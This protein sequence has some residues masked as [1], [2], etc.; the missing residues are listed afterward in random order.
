MPF[1]L[2]PPVSGFRAPPRSRRIHAPHKLLRLAPCHYSSR[3]PF[4]TPHLL[5]S[6]NLFL[7]I[8]LNAYPKQYGWMTGFEP[9]TTRSTIWDST[10]EL[11]PP[12]A[13][14][15]AELKTI[16]N[17]YSANYSSRSENPF[18]GLVAWYNQKCMHYAE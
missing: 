4:Q 11:H 15:M 1:S 8:E 5:L 9:A 17:Y 7:K 14:N 6:I 10:A 3:A 13:Y 18:F 2:Q 16:V 12:C